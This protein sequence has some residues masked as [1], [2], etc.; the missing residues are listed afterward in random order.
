MNREFVSAERKIRKLSID[1]FHVFST[2]GTYQQSA[3]KLRRRPAGD[4][5]AA[6]ASRVR[7][8]ATPGEAIT[9]GQTFVIPGRGR[10]SVNPEPK[11][12]RC[13]HIGKP[14]FLGSGPAPSVHP[15]ITGVGDW[16]F[17]AQPCRAARHRFGRFH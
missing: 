10:Q 1:A 9:A 11:K 17:L 13:E 2:G 16:G 14:V 7:A 4:P 6:A 12:R 3:A 5:L 15:G 8:M